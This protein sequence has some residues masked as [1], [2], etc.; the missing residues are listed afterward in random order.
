MIGWQEEAH[1][2]KTPYGSGEASDARETGDGFL[3]LALF[4]STHS[5]SR[6]RLLLIPSASLLYHPLREDRPSGK[7]EDDGRLST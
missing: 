2:A 6:H 1:D 3:D 7:E 4:E 5:E